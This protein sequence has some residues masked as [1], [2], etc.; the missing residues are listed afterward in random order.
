MI[1]GNSN[2]KKHYRYIPQ[3]QEKNMKQATVEFVTFRQN[4]DMQYM[5]ST[6]PK[7]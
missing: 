3:M 7:T 2:I 4:L 1:H 6:Y 5:D